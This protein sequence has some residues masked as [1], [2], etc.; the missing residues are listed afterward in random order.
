M[1]FG[2]LIQAIPSTLVAYLMICLLN[3]KKRSIFSIEGWSYLMILGGAIFTFYVV[4]A[5][6]RP[7]SMGKL[8]LDLGV[9]MYFG[10]RSLRIGL[11]EGR[12]GGKRKP[13]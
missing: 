6:G 4:Y 5:Y 3:A 8:M 12:H 2:L 7:P 10:K 1:T 11:W 13:T 9:F